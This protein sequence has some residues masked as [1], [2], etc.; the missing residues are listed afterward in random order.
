MEVVFR[1]SIGFIYDICR[2]IICKSNKREQWI[3]AFLC[4]G[5]EEEDMLYIDG[6]LKKFDGIE[7][8]SKLLGYKENKSQNALI[9]EVYVKYLRER[10]IDVDVNGFLT[11]ITDEKQLKEVMAEY[12]LGL[13]VASKDDILIAI[14][15]LEQNPEIK[16]E[17]YSFFL[18][19]DEY[20]DSLKTEFNQ[21]AQI[22]QQVYQE[23]YEKTHK[24]EFNIYNFLENLK[25]Y[26]KNDTWELEMQHCFVSFSI[27]NQYLVTRQKDNFNNGVIILGDKYEKLFLKKLKEP[28]NL[29][30]FGN[31]LGDKIRM[32]MLDL[33]SRN[34]E[35]TLTDFSNKLGIVNAVALYHLEILKEGKLI[36]RRNK[37]RRVLYWI[38]DKQFKSA[39]EEI[40]KL[41]GGV[42][43]EKL[44]E[45][46]SCN[47][48]SRTFE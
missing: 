4:E 7:I 6:L 23:E 10:V 37:G 2:V 47:G 40:K 33:L 3:N 30:S 36:L 34:G 22:M 5:S 41:V 35:L 25:E 38:N 9:G 43:D 11:Y 45:T 46:S 48:E 39:I 44:E 31:A 26:A 14:R 1:D 21:L 13:N 20:L 18:F 27:T 16:A 28:V 12:Y 8:S 32:G 19:T 17:L 29:I 42:T 24:E 15:D